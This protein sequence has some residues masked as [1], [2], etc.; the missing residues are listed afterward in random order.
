MP[1]RKPDMSH[2][3][4]KKVLVTDSAFLTGYVLLLGV[5]C[6]TRHHFLFK[7]DV[8]AQVAVVLLLLC[9]AWW[10][11]YGVMNATRVLKQKDTD[12]REV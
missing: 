10:S 5:V 3:R 4:A 12:E 8:A 9:L 6:Y 2:R 1:K 7:L 11:L